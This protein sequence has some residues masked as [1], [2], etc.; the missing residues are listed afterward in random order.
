MRNGDSM[1]DNGHPLRIQVHAQDNVAMVGN[2]GG[3]PSGAQFDSGLTLL[4]AIPEAHKVALTDIAQ[5]A[6]I[7]R[8]G[9]VIGYARA[10]IAQGS[11]VHEGGMNLPPAPPLDGLPL[12]TS[13][14][15]P[16]PPL[17]GHT[18]E[19]FLNQDGSVGTR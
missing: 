12:A 3:L 5:G 8:Y 10:P 18:F 7:V 2:E 19:G 16:S 17:E 4:E 15:V 13:V 14:P 1:S 11:W 9:E 6:P